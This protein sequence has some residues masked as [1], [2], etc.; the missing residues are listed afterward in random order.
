MRP[1]SRCA[2]AGEVEDRGGGEAVLLADQPGDHVGGFLDFEEAAARE[3][4]PACSR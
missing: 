1:S 2:A 3:C 4:G